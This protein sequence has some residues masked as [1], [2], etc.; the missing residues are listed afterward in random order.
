[1][2]MISILAFFHL[3][4]ILGWMSYKDY[5]EN[6]LNSD[7]AVSVVPFKSISVATK[8]PE[9]GIGKAEIEYCICF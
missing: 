8:T 3:N 7:E 4:Q 2:M 6:M 5:Y 1:M 9:L